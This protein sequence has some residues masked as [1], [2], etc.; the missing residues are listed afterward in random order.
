MGEIDIVLKAGVDDGPSLLVILSIG[1][2]V[3]DA[4]DLLF[5]EGC[6]DVL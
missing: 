5:R 4:D 2:D 6:G 3:E 1:I